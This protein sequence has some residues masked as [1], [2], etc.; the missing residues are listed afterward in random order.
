MATYDPS[1]FEAQRRRLLDVYA[2]QS[3]LNAYQRLIGMGNAQRG[4]TNLNERAFRTT[5]SGG[6]GE[7]PKLSSNYGRRG[8]Q[9]QGIRS[10][11]YQNALQNYASRRARD[12]GYAR[13]DMGNLDRGYEITGRGYQS[14][15]EGGMRDLEANKARQI[16]EDARAL[17]N[18]R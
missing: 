14:D 5:V 8:L 15:L 3:A 18:L 12:V 7:V 16:S 17:L 13:E 10:G 6:L 1:I 4:L 2:Q 9:G 11:V